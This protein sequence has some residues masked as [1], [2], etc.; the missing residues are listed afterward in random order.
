[1]ENFKNTTGENGEKLLEF[2]DK[3]KKQ[4]I[5]VLELFKKCPKLSPSEVYNDY[6]IQRTP[7]TSIRR[8]ISN[9][10][11]QGILQ[12]LKEK[13]D[14]LYGRPEYYYQLNQ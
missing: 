12:K 3:A 13:K 9:L 4:E 11:N 2:N 14:G 7:L 8:A 5:R 10:K 6:P 1:M